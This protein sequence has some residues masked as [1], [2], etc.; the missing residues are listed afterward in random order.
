MAG[1]TT[2]SVITFLLLDIVGASLFIGVIV[3]LGVIFQ[4]AISSLLSTL[5]DYGKF[6]LFAVFAT[7]GL[8]VLP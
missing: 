6:G 3:A 1:V 8:Y 4:D 7:I 2:M 5:V